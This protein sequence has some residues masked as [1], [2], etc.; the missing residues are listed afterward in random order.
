MSYFANILPSCRNANKANL[1]TLR[2]EFEML[3][4]KNLES[5]DDYVTRVKRW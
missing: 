2:A 3:E 1:Q 5:I 4:M